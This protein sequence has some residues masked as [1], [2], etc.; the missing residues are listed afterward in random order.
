MGFAIN[1]T[2]SA[3]KIQEVIIMALFGKKNQKAVVP[4]PV[5]QPAPRPMTE[6]E[7]NQMLSKQRVSMNQI[8]RL[9]EK[10]DYVKIR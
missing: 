5:P 2:A 3:E 9:L 4:Q 7:V 1:D 8:I 10:I 6:E